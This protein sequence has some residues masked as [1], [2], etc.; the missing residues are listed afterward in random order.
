MKRSTVSLRSQSAQGFTLV[1]MAVV[2]VIM[3]IILGG[4]LLP[5]S[6]Q[7]DM[8]NYSAAAQQLEEAKEALI[9]FAITNGRL[10]CPDIAG[11]GV[12]QVACLTSPASTNGGNLPWVTLGLQKSDPWGQP[13]QYRVNGAFSTTFTLGTLATVT[14][15]GVLN[16][17][18]DSTKTTSLASGVPAVI[19]SSGKNGA[20][21]PPVSADELENTNV[22]GATF[23]NNF[24]S[25]DFS[26]T[27][28]DVVV[29]VSPSVLINRMVTAGKLP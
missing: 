5:L 21:Q 7:H 2:L 27:F 28:D 15:A 14:G 25:R 29:W 3:G 1:E 18:T 17:W 10:P 23:D 12:E 11:T 20:T 13:L 6:T 24:V 26:P 16:V 4:L 22:A 9:G 8:Q 19:Y